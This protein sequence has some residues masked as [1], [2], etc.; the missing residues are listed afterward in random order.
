[1]NSTNSTFIFKP[2]YLLFAIFIFITEVLI[3]LYVHD[4]FIRPYVGDFLVVVF[5][6]A[7]VRSFWNK[8]GFTVAICVLIF[9]FAVEIAQYFNFVEL[10]GLQDNKIARIIIGTTYHWKD[11]VA[12]VL[13]VLA[14]YWIDISYITKSNIRK[15]K[16]S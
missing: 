13:G 5:L 10:I 12:Y 3:A 6:Y 1:M 9:S 7:L 16:P 8:S 2:K 15:N 4:N 14:I 11:L